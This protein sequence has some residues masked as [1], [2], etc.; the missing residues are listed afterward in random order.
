MLRLKL[1]NNTDWI[2]A[3]PEVETLLVARDNRTTVMTEVL[4]WPIEGAN[5]G[6]EPAGTAVGVERAEHDPL[7]P[8]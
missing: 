8:P 3:H 1:E 6:L 4:N 5:R 2:D 7:G